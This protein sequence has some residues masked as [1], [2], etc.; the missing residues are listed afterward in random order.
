MKV[1]ETWI[2]KDKTMHASN[3]GPVKI[4]GFKDTEQGQEV[5]FKYIEKTYNDCH[6][7]IDEFYEKFEKVYERAELSFLD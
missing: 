2:S 5:Y 7:K 6:W 4:I 1:G 3:W